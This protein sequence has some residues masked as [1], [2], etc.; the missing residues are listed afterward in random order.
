MVAATKVVEVFHISDDFRSLMQENAQELVNGAKKTGQVIYDCARAMDRTYGAYWFD[1]VNL[2]IKAS[3]KDTRKT[4]CAEFDS[5]GMAKGTGLVYWARVKKE[6]GHKPKEIA[7]VSTTIDAKN[8]KELATILGRIFKAE[9]DDEGAILS[10]KARR[11][12][13]NAFEAMGGN[14]LEVEGNSPE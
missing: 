7:S 6:S 8:L 2:L 13:S 9:D 12:L 5:A 3:V 11:D 14:L 4:F 10:Q 1:S